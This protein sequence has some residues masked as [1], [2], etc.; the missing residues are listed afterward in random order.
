MIKPIWTVLCER[1][2][3]DRETNLVSY[4][5]CI[6]DI[7]TAR[8]P[9]IHPRISIGS[10]WQ[11][12]APGRDVLRFKVVLVSPEGEEK[13]LLESEDYVLEM[14]RHRANINLFGIAFEQAGTYGFKLM[15]KQKEKWSTAAEIPLKVIYRPEAGTRPS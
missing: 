4:L 8:L 9:A 13:T 3:I 12:D 15:Y 10:L 1:I 5:T 7:T 14:E 11:T 2:S 6:E